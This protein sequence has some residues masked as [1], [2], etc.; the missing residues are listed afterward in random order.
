[1]LRAP[2]RGARLLI[3]T[4]A[5]HGA[6][7]PTTPALH[8]TYMQHHCAPGSRRGRAHMRHIVGVGRSPARRMHAPMRRWQRRPRGAPCEPHPLLGGGRGRRHTAATAAHPP[9]AC[10]RSRHSGA[11][12]RRAAGRAGG[13]PGA[14]RRAARGRY[15]LP[16]GVPAPGGARCVCGHARVSHAHAAGWLG[17]MRPLCPYMLPA[18][19]RMRPHATA[20]ACMHLQYTC[21]H[22]QIHL[23]ATACACMHLHAARSSHARLA[24]PQ[25][26][27][28]WCMWSWT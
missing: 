26:V 27:P 25:Q 18:F 2:P 21:M 16:L 9:P 10:P 24:R 7:A 8:P 5:A 13:S 17:R 23:H 14:G 20:C 12:Q 11:A 28:A 3:Q 6:Q 22:L 1:M 19:A 15:C 4:A